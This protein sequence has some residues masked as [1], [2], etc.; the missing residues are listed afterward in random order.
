MRSQFY[1]HYQALL[2]EL[3]LNMALQLPAK[4]GK[5]YHRVNETR[6]GYKITL[7]VGGE[8]A[9]KRSRAGDMKGMVQLCK[10]A[11]TAAEPANVGTIC[12]LRDI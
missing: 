6:E 4:T 5:V 3:G 12:T 11:T 7:S 10:A 1:E 8:I 9:C 2:N